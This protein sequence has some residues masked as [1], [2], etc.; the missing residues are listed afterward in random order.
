MEI[1][2]LGSILQLMHWVWLCL[3]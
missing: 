2:Y 3:W 1:Y